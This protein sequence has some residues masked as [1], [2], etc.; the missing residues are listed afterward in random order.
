MNVI[1]QKLIQMFSNV[2][3]KHFTI[4]NNRNLKE[5]QQKCSEV[6]I[7]L[8]ID[9]CQAIEKATREQAKSKVCFSRELAA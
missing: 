6:E 8:T 4:V 7:S 2:S 9:E 1:S 3:V 5:L